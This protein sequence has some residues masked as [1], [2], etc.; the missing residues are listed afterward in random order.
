MHVNVMDNK[1][2]NKCRAIIP[3]MESKNKPFITIKALSSLPFPSRPSVSLQVIMQSSMRKTPYK[4]A[5]AKN[6]I[7]MAR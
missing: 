2:K 5:C 4:K 1:I 6:R 7:S 3:L